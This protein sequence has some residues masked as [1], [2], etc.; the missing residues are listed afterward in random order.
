MTVEQPTSLRAD[1]RRN[2]DQILASARVLFA[3]HGAEVPM[4][5]IA[6]HAG[7][8][9][10]TLYR[11]FPDREALIREVAQE[12]FGTACVGGREALAEA[13]TAWD[14][15]VRFLNYSREVKLSV[16]LAMHS[17][18]AQRVLEED[19]RTVGY[20]D[21]LLAILDE[22]VRAAQ[23]EGTLRADVGTGDIAIMFSTLLRQLAFRD[24]EL[25]QRSTARSLALMLDSLRAEGATPLPGSP[26]T[27][28]E[29]LA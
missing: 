23:A 27:S 6:R 26:V 20:R 12:A 18:V 19:P 11:R 17:P 3:S 7:V 2:R 15:L 14:A 28:A 16:Q 5:E 9:V 21:E 1:A 24:S 25:A 10:G 13:A 4:E 29:L 22:I 8:G